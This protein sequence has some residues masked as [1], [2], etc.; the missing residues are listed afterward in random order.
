MFSNEGTTKMPRSV[1]RMGAAAGLLV[2]FLWLVWTAGRAGFASL[3][4]AYAA[5]AN[6]IASA[7]AAVN[8]SP[9]D[10]EGHLVRGA[11]LEAN[12]DLSAA[13]SEYQT[14]ASLRPDDYVF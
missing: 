13:I 14:A 2:V 10:P 9:G 12:N 3:L 8:L 7:D 11:L 5:R 1:S 6:L 4:T